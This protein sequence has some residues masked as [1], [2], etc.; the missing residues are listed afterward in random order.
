MIEKLHQIKSKIGF[1][2]CSIDI[3]VD[4]FLSWQ[5]EIG[6][7]FGYALE[8]T[9]RKGGF[10][11][12]LQ[13]LLPITAPVALRYVM[14]PTKSNWVAFIDNSNL[15]TD[16]GWMS[17]LTKRINCDAIRYV[18]TFDATIFEKYCSGEVERSLFAAK[19]GSKWVFGS[20]GDLYDFENENN[21]TKRVI[22]E[23]FTS[24]MLERYLEKFGIFV[25][26]EAFYLSDDEYILLE[27]NGKMPQNLKEYS[28]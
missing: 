20:K 9:K 2:E 24:E 8:A 11:L 3:L 12:A 13:S 19:D 18:S 17:L 5:N 25:A 1:V 28:L 14:M 16:F 21:F 27:R 23:R 4:S 6:S 15:G 26:D 10:N 22:R 7:E